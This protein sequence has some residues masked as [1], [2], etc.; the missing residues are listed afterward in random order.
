MVRRGAQHRPGSLLQAGPAVRAPTA[1]DPIAAQAGVGVRTAVAIPLRGKIGVPTL[2][3]ELKI[4]CAFHHEEPN[5]LSY[6]QLLCIA[7]F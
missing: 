7:L 6:I 2:S 5:Q 3:R 1:V 4:W